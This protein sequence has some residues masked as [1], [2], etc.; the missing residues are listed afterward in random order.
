MMDHEVDITVKVRGRE[1]TFVN[2]FWDREGDEFSYDEVTGPCAE[3]LPDDLMAEI[4]AEGYQAAYQAE[5][6]RKM[7]EADVRGR[8]WEK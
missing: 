6:E 2:A 5:Q 8:D 7:D 4:D 1:W 3:F